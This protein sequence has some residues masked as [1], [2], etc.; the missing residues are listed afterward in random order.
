MKIY[1]YSFDYDYYDYYDYDLL[2][3]VYDGFHRKKYS[4]Y[5]NIIK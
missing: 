2:I 3:V 1:K 5:E 4:F